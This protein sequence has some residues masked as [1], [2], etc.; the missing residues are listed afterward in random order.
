MKIAEKA[1]ADLAK[2]L[3]EQG[4]PLSAAVAAG[5]M[6]CE[7]WTV[8]A[9]NILSTARSLGFVVIGSQIYGIDE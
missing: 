7:G 8:N 9:E 1:A 4:T 3:K 2:I 6:R 5:E